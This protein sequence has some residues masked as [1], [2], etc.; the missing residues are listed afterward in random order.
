MARTA[1]AHRARR[2]GDCTRM[3]ELMA[4]ITIG[5]VALLVWKRWQVMRFFKRPTPAGAD[6]T[7]VSILQP[8]LSGDPTL[9]ECLAQ[10]LRS[11]SRY[12]V[13]FIW[14][15]DADDAVAQ[16]VCADLIARYPARP[17]RVVSLPPPGY[18]QNP[19]LV[20]LSEGVRAAQ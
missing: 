12:R 15:L 8:I 6:P 1:S 3:N 7:L 14:L 17:V 13:E 11:K 4:L 9:Q 2:Q 20:K 18:D 10:N 5:Y 16:R 19:K